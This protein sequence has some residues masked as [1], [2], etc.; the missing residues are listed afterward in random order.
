MKKNH[1]KKYYGYYK[2]NKRD[3]L[4]CGILALLTLVIVYKMHFIIAIHE[5]RGFYASLMEF[6]GSWYYIFEVIDIIRLQDNAIANEYGQKC[7]FYHRYLS[8]AAL[9]VS[10]FF[11][12][13]SLFYELDY[14]VALLIWSALTVG[15]MSYFIMLFMFDEDYYYS[16][17]F[18]ICYSEINHI[19]VE[20]EVYTSK[21]LVVVCKLMKDEKVIGYDRMVAQDFI[22]LK[23]K[24]DEK[25]KIVKSYEGAINND[26]PG[27]CTAD[28]LGHI[29]YFNHCTDYKNKERKGK[30]S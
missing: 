29:V 14:N 7:I 17:G 11:I 23:A 15:H 4:I 19:E 26:S 13:F 10:A 6:I 24:I 30:N 20:D 8:L 22:C 25:T 16:G 12:I 18:K 1:Y 5:N 3:L 27:H 2:K 21:A 9:L 28:F